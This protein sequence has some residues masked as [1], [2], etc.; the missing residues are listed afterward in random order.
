M[1]SSSRGLVY[2]WVGAILIAF[3]TVSVLLAKKSL[4]SHA[5]SETGASKSKG[6]DSAPVQIVEYSDFQCPSC[7]MVQAPLAVLMTSYPGKL[8][9]T[10]RHFPLEAHRHAALA[11]QAAE[12]AG[13]EGRFWVYHDRLYQ[14]Q[15]T[16][17][18]WEE[19]LPLF[20]GYARELGLDADRFA[21][22]LASPEV[23][24][25]VNRDQIAGQTVGVN[26][27]PT[28]FV[29]G[30]MLVGSRQFMERIHIVIQEELAKREKWKDRPF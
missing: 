3:L 26:S 30:V 18:N 23:A 29:N 20:L 21:A 15:E 1:M 10:F 12:C 17:S 28:F 4:S 8:H 24:G 22:C 9:V 19:P 16:W 6:L 5:G 14:D 13:L 25:R 2:V 7:K 11:H 27:T